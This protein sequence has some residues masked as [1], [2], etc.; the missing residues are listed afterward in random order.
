MIWHVGH[1]LWLQDVL[2][3]GLLTGSEQLPTEWGETFGA[4]CRSPA[5]T[6][7]WPDREKLTG[8]LEQQLEQMIELLGGASD[9]KL[10]S[11]ADASRGTATIADR[12]I[13]GLHDEAR[14]TGEM[15]LLAKL[16]RVSSQPAD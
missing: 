6:S 7:D 16:W 11:V 15:H 3:V 12:I 14:H 5:E 2:C 13:H 8:M 9:E 10:L 4:R 1:A